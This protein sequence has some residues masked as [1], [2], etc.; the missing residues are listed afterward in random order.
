MHPRPVGGIERDIACLHQHL[1]VLRLGHFPVD[2][3]EVLRPELAGRL[4]HEQDL[5]IDGVVHG[6]SPL[7]VIVLDAVGCAGSDELHKLCAAETLIAA[8]AFHNGN[9]LASVQNVA[10]LLRPQSNLPNLWLPAIRG[11]KNVQQVYAVHPDRDGAWHCDGD[12]R[13]QLSARQPGGNRGGRKPDRHAVPAADQDDHRASGVRHARR[14]HRAYGLA[15]PSWAACSPRRWAGSS[16][17]PLSRCCSA[18]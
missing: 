17:P 18:S 2:H 3:L 5:A 14:R 16:A 6:V 8:R 11:C 7:G 9:I 1:A 4:F 12:H 10:S 13:L 15:A